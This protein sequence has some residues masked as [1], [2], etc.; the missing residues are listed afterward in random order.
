MIR[1]DSDS[2]FTPRNAFAKVDSKYAAIGP[3]FV[4]LPNGRYRFKAREKFIPPHIKQLRLNGHAPADLEVEPR[5]EA[6]ARD[7]FNMQ[8]LIP[9]NA[10]QP[11]PVAQGNL[12]FSNV[13]CRRMPRLS[14]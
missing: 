4:A 1:I 6:M 5:I 12:F 3:R 10:R 14:A 8:V 11:K 2:H 9:N 13:R 7:G